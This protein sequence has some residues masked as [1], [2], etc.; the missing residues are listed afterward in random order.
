MISQN[1][2]YFDYNATHPPFADILS[3][4]C[5]DYSIHYYNPS[6]AGRFS[7]QRQGLIEETRKYFAGLF[8]K[9]EE[10]IVFCSTG[11]EA[12]LLILGCLKFSQYNALTVY[13]SGLEH[14]SI[15]GAFEIL[16]MDYEMIPLSRRGE[17]DLDFLDRKMKIS[18]RPVVL[19][20]AANESGIIP[21]LKSVSVIC[22]REGMPL[23]SDQM[24]A[25]GKIN[26]EYPNL[27]AFSCS[28]H[29][30]GAG[31]GASI[32]YIPPEWKTGY[33]IFKGGNQENGFRAGT[34][35]SAAIYS[36]RMASERQHSML[37]GKNDRLLAFRERIENTL[38]EFGSEIVGSGISRLPGT[39]FAI[40]KSEDIDFLLIGLEEKG[41][42]ISTGSSCKSRSREPALSLLNMGYSKEEALRAV[43]ISFG[44][45][46]SEDDLEYLLENL[47]SLLTILV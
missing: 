17:I 9:K 26:I 33:R 31:I 34:E 10:G 24:Q 11:T 46:N 6:G 22:R 15:Y 25:F 21:D 36:F 39:C 23:I 2:C 3:T 12:N 47:R 42:V 43:R 18:P 14:S 32:A 13:V 37:P 27:D 1:I 38:S 44:I 45:F 30:I 20:G 16:G 40:L 4:A 28:G 8:G 41:I 35:N 19:I 5:I 29:K 7:M